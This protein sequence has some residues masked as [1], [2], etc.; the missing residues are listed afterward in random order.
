M[1]D[2]R[3]IH[4]HLTAQPGTTVHITV[5]SDDIAVASDN[6]EPNVKIV[7]TAASPD[8]VLEAAIQRLESSG[9]SP[10]VRAA[11]EGLRALGYLLKPGRP[12]VPGKPPENY[13][14]IIDPRH[15]AP[16][17]G[18]LWPTYFGFTRAA[19]QERLADLPGAEPQPASAQVKFSH[20]ESVEPGLNAA[21]LLKD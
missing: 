10:N 18:Y 15:P 1:T 8:D 5:A 3:D 16:A 6:A 7:D 14:R 19:D 17:V 13:L 21:R 12:N 11:V 2:T 4:I 20:V 9:A